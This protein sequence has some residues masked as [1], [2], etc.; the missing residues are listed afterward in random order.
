MR[1]LPLLVCLSAMAASEAVDKALAKWDDEVLVAQDHRNRSEERL[2]E[3]TL[4]SLLYAA[5]S[6]ARRG[7][8]ADASRCWKEVLRLD[9]EHE[10]A[11]AFFAATGNLDEVITEVTTPVDLFGNPVV[12]KRP[13]ATPEPKVIDAATPT[14]LG[15]LAAGTKLTFSYLSGRWNP[16]VG[17]GMASPDDAKLPDSYR[18]VLAAQDARGTLLVLETIP[19][20]T[21]AKPFTVTLNQAITNAI[22]CLNPGP[23]AKNN[24]VGSITYAVTIERP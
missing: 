3:R 5:T 14:S 17:L 8:I 24:L 18:L 20:D 1:W 23:G 15:N 6:A 21:S 4:R 2:T 13:P 12:T 7:D 10:D 11:R 9:P 19:A 22:L 16:R